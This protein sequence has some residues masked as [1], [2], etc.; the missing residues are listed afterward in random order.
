M[1]SW[2]PPA[3]A[4]ILFSVLELKD[5]LDQGRLSMGQASSTMSL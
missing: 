4:Q 3:E 1:L 5:D 2:T